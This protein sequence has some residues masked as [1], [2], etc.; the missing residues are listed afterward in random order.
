MKVSQL[1]GNPWH[2]EQLHKTCKDESKYCVYNHKICSCVVNKKYYHNQCVGKGNCEWFEPKTGTPKIYSDKIY[3]AS[4]EK[5]VQKEANKKMENKQV[6][7]EK[8]QK[9][10]ETAEKRVNTI[11]LKIEGLENLSDKSRYEYTEE[12][13]NKMFGSIEQTLASVKESFTNK[14]RK[15][16]KF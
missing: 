11:I 8:H 13:I 9:F 7:N 12:E 15:R 5:N 6:L 14:S 2:K 4:S 16:F 1:Q 10:L 3:K